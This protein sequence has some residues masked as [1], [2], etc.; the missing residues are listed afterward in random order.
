MGTLV[1]ILSRPPAI[2]W[3]LSHRWERN[4]P[5]RAKPSPH[6]QKEKGKRRREAEKR[7]KSPPQILWRSVL[8]SLGQ[9]LRLD[10]L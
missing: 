5:R 1:P 7:E 8:E 10:V 2:L 4:S 9:M 6:L 3:F